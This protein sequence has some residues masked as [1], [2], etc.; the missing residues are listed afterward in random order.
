MFDGNVIVE[1]GLTGVVE[2]PLEIELEAQK[3]IDVY[4]FKS[5]DGNHFSIPDWPV[6][7]VIDKVHNYLDKGTKYANNQLYLVGALIIL[8]KLPHN[9]IEKVVLRNVLDQVF[10]LLKRIIKGN[11]V[12]AVVCSEL[13]YRSFYEATNDR[14][15]GLTIKDALLN[16]TTNIESHIDEDIVTRMNEIEKMYLEVNSMDINLDMNLYGKGNP[17]VA[18]EMVSPNDLS[19]SPNLEMIGR[20]KK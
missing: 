17:L 10:K 2:T 6:S 19:L 3:Y 1:A 7:P 11:E 8:R 9:H 14:K 16:V 15:Y 20:L 12:K 4:R 13:V 5:D 18:A